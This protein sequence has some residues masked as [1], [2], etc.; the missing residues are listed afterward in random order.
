MSKK[1]H[2]TEDHDKNDEHHEVVE[3]PAEDHETPDQNEETPSAEEPSGEVS[4]NEHG[5]VFKRCWQWILSHKK[6]SIPLLVVLVLGLLTAI[7]FSRYAIAGTFLKQN[8][9]VVVIDAETGK[10]VSE[11]T[12]S[13]NGATADTDSEGR[14]T[15]KTR[16]GNTKL[17]VAKKYYEGASQN[18][19]VPISKQ[20]MPQEVKLKAT[21][22]PV[23][24]SVLN[25][26]SKKPAANITITAEGTEAKTDD[27]GKTTLVVPADKTEVAAKLSGEGFNSVDIT[28]KVTSEEVEPNIFS[29]TPSGKIYFL[30]N[31][32]GKLDL[33]K[34]DLDGINRQTVLAGT[35]KEDK[36]NTVLLASRD[37]KYIALLS[38]RDGGE[39]AKLFLIETDDDKLTTMD[40]GEATFEVFGWSGDRFVYKVTREKMKSWEPKRQALKSYHAPGKKITTLAETAAEGSESGYVY[41]YFD[42]IFVLDQTIAF[43]TSWN[44]GNNGYALWQNK[45]ASLNSVLADGSQKKKIKDYND[46]YLQ[47]RT[48]EFGEIYIRYHE[49]EDDYE[50]EKVDEYRDGKVSVA[51]LKPG[52][53]YNEPYP[54]YSVSPSGNKTLWSE[55]RD[56]KNAFFVGDAKGEN[57]KEIGRA[58][59]YSTYGWFSDNYLL[60]TKKSS[61]MYIL[62]ADGIDGG[63]EKA[64]KISD[65]YKPDYYNRG[66]GYGYG[67]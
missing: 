67:G 32:S 55:S 40:E 6:F 43:T 64:L 34:S 57:G 1:S 33:V 25:K 61:E 18:I 30:S 14:A 31:A 17:E 66:F 36:N 54:F 63:L 19:L 23:P 2:K 47:T 4:K 9:S 5:H 53:F 52:D 49:N 20:S 21:G 12:V 59:E 7:P 10:A 60:L 26:I 45:R 50:N 37:W 39:Y 41:E 22:R 29:V 13:L 24:L 16:V 58:D 42:S 3:S 48:A 46:H 8:Y 15:I 11:A 62:P 35:G 56:G 65:Y 38:K 44:S 27:Q 51:D 28:L